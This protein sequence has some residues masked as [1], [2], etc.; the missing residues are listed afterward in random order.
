VDI[1]VNKI[2]E[3]VWVDR[4]RKIRADR[5]LQFFGR[6]R[7]TFIYLFVATILVMGLNHYTEIQTLTYAQLIIALKH[8]PS[9]D[10]LR[11]SALNYEKQVDDIAK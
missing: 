4:R 6:V 10:K 1:T 2:N 8:S 7:K 5:R 9:S 11:Q 3:W